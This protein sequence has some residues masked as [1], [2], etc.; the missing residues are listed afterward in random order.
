MC[1]VRV[2]ANI[3]IKSPFELG[4]DPTMRLQ[5]ATRPRAFKYSHD[6]NISSS[7]MPSSSGDIH[8]EITIEDELGKMHR[9]IT[10]KL[11]ST[12]RSEVM[13]G[14]ATLVWLSINV[15]TQKVRSLTVDRY[16]SKILT[17]F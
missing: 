5:V 3:A 11:L 9:Y 16:F 13:C 1:L 17:T 4:W 2:I 7:E 14:R 10:T 6:S 12:T 15:E 8:W